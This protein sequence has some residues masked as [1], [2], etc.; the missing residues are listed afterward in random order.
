MANHFRLY[1]LPREV[2]DV[3][4]P[5]SITGSLPDYSPGDAFSGR[6]QI[7][8]P[9]GKCKVEVLD[10]TSLPPGYVVY[11]D[12][13]TKEVVIKWDAYQDFVGESNPVPN[14]D[15]EF[16]NDGSWSGPGWEITTDGPETG[17]KSAKYAPG[18]FGQ[19]SLQGAAVPVKVNDTIT[20]TCRFQQGASSKGNLVGQVLLI[21]C[22]K[23]GAV[24]SFSPGTLI[25]SG[26]GGEWKTSEVTASAPANGT[27]RA[28]F[29]ANRKRQNLACWVDNF[30]WNHKYKTGTSDS[31]DFFLSIKV[32]DSENRVAYW[33]GSLYFGSFWLSGGTY[34]VYDSEK[35][36]AEALFVSAHTA[37][38]LITAN[39]V[40]DGMSAEAI[41]IGASTRGLNWAFSQYPES[42]FA[43]AVLINAFT[44]NSN[45]S[46]NSGSEA[47]SATATLISA[48]TKQSLLTNTF[49]PE[50]LTASATFIGAST[51]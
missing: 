10:G 13:I 25:N 34:P 38:G 46:Y 41:L 2:H 40:I 45:V 3:D 8:N 28:G 24:Q 33:S 27:V 32:T 16:G 50:A 17:T 26:S 11:V 30:S 18:N 42:M 9:I 12:Q 5:I 36:S 14:G 43:E 19:S 44:R 15:F 35:I 47:I 1:D 21:W 7:N 37:V 6:L 23:D 22:D 20:L 49:T 29:S 31:L 48:S 4:P 39:T 51:A